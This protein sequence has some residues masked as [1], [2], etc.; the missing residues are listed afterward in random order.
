MCAKKIF[1]AS[2]KS[3]EISAIFLGMKN[4][5]SFENHS[6]SLVIVLVVSSRVCTP[7][8]T[9]NA[10]SNVQNCQYSFACASLH[11]YFSKMVKTVKKAK[12]DSAPRISKSKTITYDRIM[13]VYFNSHIFKQIEND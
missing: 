3:S 13:Q 12:E 5:V 9:L 11:I 6:C 7:I 2:M 4:L 1:E 8:L 10:R